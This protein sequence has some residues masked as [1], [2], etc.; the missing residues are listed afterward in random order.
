VAATLLMMAE[1]F[2]AQ[3][4]ALAVGRGVPIEMAKGLF[5]DTALA[6]CLLVDALAAEM[7]IKW[8][9]DAHHVIP[10]EPDWGALIKR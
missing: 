6:A 8:R 9:R 7:G 1:R 2:P 4:G 10:P 3:I 5:A